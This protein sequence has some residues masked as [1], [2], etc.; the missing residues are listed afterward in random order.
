VVALVLVGVDLGEGRDRTM[1][2][3]GGTEVTRD[4]HGVTGSRVG[5]GERPRARPVCEGALVMGAARTGRIGDQ[6]SRSRGAGTL[7]FEL[8]GVCADGGLAVLLASTDQFFAAFQLGFALSLLRGCD[9]SL[10][11]GY[12]AA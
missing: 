11:V 10:D 6:S 7:V 5:A 2:H 3:P 4:R 8:C 1:E 9:L 12:R